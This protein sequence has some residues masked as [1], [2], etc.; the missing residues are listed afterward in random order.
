MCCFSLPSSPPPPPANVLNLKNKSCSTLIVALKVLND[1]LKTNMR[2]WLRRIVKMVPILLK[3]IVSSP[4]ACISL[5]LCFF[6]QTSPSSSVSQCLLK[7]WD[8][9]SSEYNENDY[10]RSK[11]TSSH[12][13]SNISCILVT[14]DELMVEE[15]MN[16]LNGNLFFYIA[17]GL[18]YHCN[19][20]MPRQSSSIDPPE[21][22][23]LQISFLW[24][25]FSIRLLLRP[26]ISLFCKNILI[27]L[28]CFFFPHG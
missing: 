9:C 18:W 25:F 19:F 12:L 21:V 17:H 20:F 13:S 22:K 8:C 16:L 7:P 5:F 2:K 24:R 14:C 6:L 4:P 15:K 1:C 10:W 3:K 23:I 27:S 26:N 11:C 28:L